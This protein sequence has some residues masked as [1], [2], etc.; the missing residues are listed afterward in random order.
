MCMENNSFIAYLKKQNISKLNLE[1]YKLI[2]TY[3]I[4]FI[5]KSPNILHESILVYDVTMIT[6]VIL[7]VSY[8]NEKITIN[9]YF[10]DNTLCILL[11]TFRFITFTRH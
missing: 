5:I 4:Y 7:H 2:S 6:Y 9:Q 11:V 3:F 10:I 1:F 8:R